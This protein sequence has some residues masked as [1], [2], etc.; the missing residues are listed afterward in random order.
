VA[1]YFENPR[2][3]GSLEASAPNVGTGL[4]GAPAQGDVVRLQISV[5]ES[6][7]IEQARFKTHG[8]GEAI[9]A[10][11]LATE[12]LAGKTLDQAMGIGNAAIARELSLPPTKIHCSMLVEDAIRAA[13]G[14]YREK[15]QG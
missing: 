15:H 8:C 6:G 4:A 12:W 2:N 14:N 11:S 3:V 7:I 9:A 13:V 10:S 1:D 5:D